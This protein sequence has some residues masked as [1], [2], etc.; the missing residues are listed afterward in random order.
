VDEMVCPVCKTAM[1]SARVVK[2]LFQAARWK[3]LICHCICGEAYEIR[4]SK[5]DILE[6]SAVSRKREEIPK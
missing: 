4:S 1:V 6:I 2:S 3:A 5:E